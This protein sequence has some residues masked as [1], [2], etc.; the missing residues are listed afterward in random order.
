MSAPHH[1]KLRENVSVIFFDS[2]L[3]EIF[4]ITGGLMKPEETIIGGF[5]KVRLYV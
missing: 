2:I 5:G 3:I 4:L 1:W